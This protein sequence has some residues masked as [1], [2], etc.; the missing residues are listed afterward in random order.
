[1]A[2]AAMIL[3][4]S[5]GAAASDNGN[6]QTLPLQTSP[7][8]FSNTYDAN[9]DWQYSFAAQLFLGKNI[10]TWKNLQLNPGITLGYVNTIQQSGTVDQF[11]LP[12]FD[13]LNYQYSLESFSAM[14]T[15]NLLFLT[16][17]P[18]QPYL[19]GSVGCSRNDAFDYYETPRI[20]GAI[21]MPS[22][23]ENA[24][25][26][27]AYSLGAGLRYRVTQILSLGL[28]YQ[29]SDLGE[30]KLGVSSAQQTT[31]T[32]SLQHFFTNELLIDFA[33]NLS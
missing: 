14:G 32:P 1:M 3:D 28:G 8:S 22:F 19:N 26:A 6:T 7:Q 17:S 25:Y 23:S 29:F 4:F 18:W 16:H 21:P 11:S 27:F 24:T 31:Q 30:T 9:N 13:N 12:G 10:Y 2:H 20:T 33:W 15:L 5:P